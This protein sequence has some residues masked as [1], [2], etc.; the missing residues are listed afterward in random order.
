MR[1]FLTIIIVATLLPV[2]LWAEQFRGRVVDASNG[3]PVATVLVRNLRTGSMWL[4]DSSGNI[5]FSAAAG[6]EIRLEHPSYNDYV[7]TIQT[8]ADL[9]AV[10][11]EK[12]PIMLQGV[13]VLSPYARFS[14]DS[15]FMRDYFHKEIGYSGSQVKLDMNGGIGTSGLISELALAVSGRKKRAKQFVEDLQMLESWRYEAIRYTPTLVMAQTGLSDSAAR[16]FILQHP[17]PL[18][19][20]R[21]GSEM[22]LKMWVRDEFRATGQTLP[23]HIQDPASESHADTTA[24][25]GNH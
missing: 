3:L 12:A 10:R 18:D 11:M 13:E 9:I 14:R 5:A 24:L 17:M 7:L 25:T 16:S 21:G 2:S 20:L 23:E 15:A 22:A 1:R 19:L 6:D 4:G 8:V